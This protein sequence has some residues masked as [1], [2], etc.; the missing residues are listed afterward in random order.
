MKN[1][2]Y[3]GDYDRRIFSTA[4]FTLMGV[5]NSL[6]LRASNGVVILVRDD[7]AEALLLMMPDEFEEVSDEE[8]K[9]LAEEEEDS[10][11]PDPE[12]DQ[13]GRDEA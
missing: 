2:R 3:I 9:A 12:P 11:N 10:G 5:E 7:E 4:D 1:I 13:D 8:L 6:G